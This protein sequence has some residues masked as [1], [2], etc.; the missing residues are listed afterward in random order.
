MTGSK[1]NH[2]GNCS[3]KDAPDPGPYW[4]RIHRD[5]R[6]W[7]GAPP[8][9]AALAIYVLSGDLSRLPHGHQFP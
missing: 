7:L 1:H 6:F 2:E 3:D 5:W 9:A 8:M 4:K